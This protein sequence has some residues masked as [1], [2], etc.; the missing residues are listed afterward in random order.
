M[1]ER[2]ARDRKVAG[3]IPG[4]GGWRVFLYKVNFLRLLLF[5]VR[6]TPVL[7]QC[8]EQDP[9]K[10]PKV[11]M[12]GYN[13]EHTVIIPSSQQSLHHVDHVVQA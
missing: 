7:P 1:I 12:A 3:S 2:R 11:Q 8:H 4:K 10:S 9:G 5:S 13:R 6:S